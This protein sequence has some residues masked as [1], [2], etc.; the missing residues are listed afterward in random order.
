MNRLILIIC[1][2]IASMQEFDG[3][4]LFTPSTQE[5]DS[6]TT[7]LMNNNYDTVHTWGHDFL[8]AS[9]P[10]LF[11]DSSI[12]YPY[13]VEFPSMFAGGVGGGVQKLSWNGM[14]IWDY[15]FA[16]TI[17]QHHHDVEP[18]PN[19]NILIIVWERKTIME[20][21]SMGRS[22]IEEWSFN[23]MWSTAI[24][25]LDPSSGLIV[26]EWHL[27]DHLLQDVNYELPNFGIIS[28]HPELFDINCGSVGN[29]AGGPQ[30]L[31]GDWMHVNAIDYNSDLDQIVISSRLQSE[32]Y[33]I[34]H[35]TTTEEAA[36]HVG[37]NSGK[38]GD[39]LYRWGNPQNYNR[40]NSSDKILASQHSVNWIPDDYPGSGNLILFNNFHGQDY[41]AVIEFTTPVDN[42]GNYIISND[43]P[44]GPTTLEWEF[45]CDIIVPMQGGSFRLPNGNTIITLTHIGKIFEVDGNGNNVWEYTHTS[46]QVD[47]YWIA[48]ADKYSLDYLHNII[49][50]DI[51]GDG[52]L[53]ILD[54]VLMINMILDN[55]YSIVADV[56]EDGAVDILDVVIMVNILVGGLP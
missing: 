25:E 50:G 36:S 52:I 9:M 42:S 15:T 22:D 5:E 4:T 47:N 10:Y 23:E 29:S 11:P 43:D 1:F 6:T 45:P 27:W 34:D 48:R 39:I 40:G 12:I 54:I 31:N 46:D 2:S 26:W 53:N 38:G 44:F 41:S 28:D 21:Y 37:G 30:G 17:Y 8:P 51:N 33:I 14:V 35:S 20:A 49:L 3:Y 55:E 24:L 19:G 18:L 16:D 7:I 32:L 13:M 56:N